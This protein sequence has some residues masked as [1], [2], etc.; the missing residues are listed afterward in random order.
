VTEI[1]AVIWKGGSLQL[2]GVFFL[3]PWEV[4][5][6][7]MACRVWGGMKDSQFNAIKQQK[8]A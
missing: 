2:E 5:V 8:V 1:G 3:Q 6:V 7:G 4:E